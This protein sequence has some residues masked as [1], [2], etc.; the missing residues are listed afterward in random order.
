MLDANNSQITQHAGALLVLDR[1]PPGRARTC[2]PA[3][4]L[5]VARPLGIERLP[6]GGLAVGILTW[7]FAL[8]DAS[9][10]NMGSPARFV[11]EHA[12]GLAA[13]VDLEGKV[14]VGSWIRGRAE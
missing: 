13:L 8:L 4:R 6:R 1:L 10:E 12:A 3:A 2:P 5:L 11:T 9:R 14:H 7:K